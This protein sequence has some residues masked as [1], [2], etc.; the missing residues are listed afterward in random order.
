[1]AASHFAGPADVPP[2]FEWPLA[3]QSRRSKRTRPLSLFAQINLA[4]LPRP[5]LDELPPEGWLL[6]FLDAFDIAMGRK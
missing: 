3:R 2:D 1:M 4:E 5:W 6:F